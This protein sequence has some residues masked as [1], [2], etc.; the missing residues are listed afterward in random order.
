M[1]NT[2][3]ARAITIED[4]GFTVKTYHCLNS[5]EFRTLGDIA[6]KTEKELEKVRDLGKKTKGEI[7]MKLKEYKLSLKVDV[8]AEY[9]EYCKM[10]SGKCDVEDVGRN[11]AFQVLM[12]DSHGVIETDNWGEVTNAGTFDADGCAIEGGMYDGEIF[13]LTGVKTTVKV[14]KPEKIVGKMGVMEL[15]LP[16]CDPYCPIEIDPN[17]WVHL[18]AIPVLPTCLRPMGCDGKRVS[19]EAKLWNEL[20]KLNFSI[21]KILETNPERKSEL[22]EELQKAVNAVYALYNK[23]TIHEDELEMQLFLYHALLPIA[24]AEDYDTVLKRI[25]TLKDMV[26]LTRLVHNAEDYLGWI[27][28]LCRICNVVGYDSDEIANCLEWAEN[29]LARLDDSLR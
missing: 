19:N 28:N 21:P 2:N 16:V 25:N 17:M 23:Q 7:L 12:R 6:D 15:A 10:E 29:L 9:E 18:T 11:I 14:T 5:A 24:V 1:L 27:R 26:E 20:A 3:Q 4:A 8:D 22:Q 13:G